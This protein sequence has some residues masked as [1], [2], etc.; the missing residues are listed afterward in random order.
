MFPALISKA[1]ESAKRALKAAI[2]HTI[3]KGKKALTIGFDCSWSH[4]RN[5][6]QASGEFVYLEELEDYGHKAVVAFHVVE[7]SRI[8]IKKGKD[9]TSEEKVV[10]HQGNIDASSRQMEHAILIALLEQIIPIL[11]ESD[12]LLEVCIDRDLD[13]NKT[14]ANV[15]IVSEIYAYLKHASKNI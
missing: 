11:E 13:S 2:T 5:A 3:T 9:G 12:L 6:K 8:I 15:P 1:E 14:L 7:K 4:S 10:I